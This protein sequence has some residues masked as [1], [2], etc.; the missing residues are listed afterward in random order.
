MELSDVKEIGSLQD[1]LGWLR[2]QFKK[3]TQSWQ[4]S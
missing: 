2:S 1:N 3:G 4:Q